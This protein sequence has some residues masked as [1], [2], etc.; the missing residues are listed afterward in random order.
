[1]KEVKI[2]RYRN[3]LTVS[4]LGVIMLSGWNV[5]KMILIFVTQ[6]DTIE[7]LFA[8]MS[9]DALVKNITIA[10]IIAII[11]IDS[12]IRLFVGLNARAVGGKDQRD[13]SQTS[14]R[15]RRKRRL[16]VVRR[17]TVRL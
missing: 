1:M 17:R 6:R 3:L 2:R 10:I 15:T 7:A 9:V 8:K 12:L 4:G 5:L 16:E 13:N 14:V 11:L